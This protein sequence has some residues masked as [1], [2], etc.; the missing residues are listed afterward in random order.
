MIPTVE[1][2]ALGGP[3]AAPESGRAVWLAVIEKAVKDHKELDSDAHWYVP[4]SYFDSPDFQI[5]CHM[6]GVRPI[7]VLRA[8]GIH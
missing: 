4:R 6:A 1:G 7:A 8:N 2:Y 3:N 5:V